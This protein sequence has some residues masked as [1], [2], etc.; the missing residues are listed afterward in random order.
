MNHIRQ[1]IKHILEEVSVIDSS[2]EVEF[3]AKEMI[4]DFYRTPKIRV[5]AFKLDGRTKKRIG[6]IIVGKIRVKRNQH[7]R[8][9]IPK[10][11]DDVVNLENQGKHISQ[12]W[13]VENVEVVENEKGKGVGKDLYKAAFEMIKKSQND[14]PHAVVQSRCTGWVGTTVEARRVWNSLSTEYETSG[15]VLYLGS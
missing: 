8:D 3:I 14:G 4:D 13:Y 2:N 11:F 9:A 12:I 7:L 10:C 5:D 6:S 1:L 15:W